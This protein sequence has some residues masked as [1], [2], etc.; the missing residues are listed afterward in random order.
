MVDKKKDKSAE[1]AALEAEIAA[2]EAAEAED[3]ARA[4]DAVSAAE[5]P[6]DPAD[7]KLRVSAAYAAALLPKGYVG[8][9][10]HGPQEKFLAA[11]ASYGE[12][13]PIAASLLQA[14]AIANINDKNRRAGINE[15]I[16][17][18]RRQM[19]FIT[20]DNVSAR[21]QD[22]IGVV[23]FTPEIEQVEGEGSRAAVNVIE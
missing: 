21:K 1:D 9:R 17:D 15:V 16:S 8:L 14:S 10:G 12:F 13:A 5:A 3:A 7:T 20:G 19:E 4:E 23:S 2:L 6:A 22:A 11:I 18:M